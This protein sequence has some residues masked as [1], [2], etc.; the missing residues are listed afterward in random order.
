[1]T[2]DSRVLLTGA[3]GFVGQALS[4]LLNSRG[5]R[6]RAAVRSS[7]TVPGA[8][9]AALVGDIGPHTDWHAALKDVDCI[10]HLAARVHVMKDTAV[11]PLAA[12]REVNTAGTVHLAKM[13]VE[14]SVRRLI[15]VSSIKVNG[16]STPPDKPFTETDSPHPEDAYG[17]SKLEAEHALT[18][19]ASE[20]GLEVVIVRPPLVYGPHVKGNILR[21]LRWIERGTPLPLAGIQ[22]K[23]SLVSA[24]NLSD[25]LIHCINHPAAANEV[26]LIS[27]DTHLSTP[28]LVQKLAGALDRPA[29]LVAVPEPL[30]RLLLQVLKK[31]RMHRQ[32]WG[33]LV[34]SS[35]KAQSQLGWTPRFG[36]DESMQEMAAAYLQ[37]SAS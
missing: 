29:R 1:M 14:H 21:L 22:N 15:Y 30:V 2:D 7:L 12:F 25:F 4:K 37:Q 6:F 17:I 36:V 8:D 24:G 35:D 18:Q 26:F 11:D 9:E 28:Q 34:V 31:D 3:S 23:R 10:I 20:T 5:I 19:I 13:A 27:D 16:E 33:S 32:L